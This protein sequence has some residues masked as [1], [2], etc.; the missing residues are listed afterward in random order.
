MLA[1]SVLVIPKVA[2]EPLQRWMWRATPVAGR[3]SPWQRAAG[4]IYVHELVRQGP[5]EPGIY[6]DEVIGHPLRIRLLRRREVDFVV[7]C[8]DPPL[9]TLTGPAIWLF[10]GGDDVRPGI[11]GLHGRL[12]PR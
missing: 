7:L 10:C 12:T 11:P 6:V 2:T 5:K 1:G 9:M 8:D 3:R 4:V